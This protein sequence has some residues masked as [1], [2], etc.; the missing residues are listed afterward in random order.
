MPVMLSHTSDAS[1]RIKR[2]PLQSTCRSIY[3]ALLIMSTMLG[4]PL[5]HSHA[6][7]FEFPESG[8]VAATR[9]G[10]AVSGITDAT[11]GFLNPGVLSRLKGFHFSYNHNLIWSDV[12]FT[13]SPSVIPDPY[14]YDSDPGTVRG[15][16][17]GPSS[18]TRSFFPING[19]IALSYQLD[20]GLTLGVS[21]NG[22]NGGGASSFPKQGGQRYMMTKLDAVL[23][24]AGASVAYGGDNWGVG[25]TL[26]LA[27]MP[28]MRYRMVV[29]GE[30]SSQLNPALSALDI[31]AELEV[32]DPAAFTALIGAWFRPI[33]SFEIAISGRVLPVQ[34]E[35]T[36]KV[37]IYNTPN[38]TVYAPEQLVINNSS[39]AF[40]F[41]LPQTAR[42]GLRYRDLVSSDEEGS[43]ERFD[44]E[45]A[46]VYERW[47][48]MD[49][50]DIKLSG[51]VVALN[52]RALQDVQIDKKWRDTFSIRLGGSFAITEV[53][54]LSA[55]GFFEQGATPRQYAHIDFPSF[56]R[57]GVAGGL[58]YQV[59]DNLQLVFGYLHI[60]ESQV[61]VSEL[62][63]KVFQQRP[64]SPCDGADSCGRSPSGEPYSGIPANAGTHRASFRTFTVG[65][66]AS[67]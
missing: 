53:L 27:T 48:V 40:E 24:F 54:G 32:S 31:E 36:G 29:D 8:S 1:Q 61:V 63:A 65:M 43:K 30:N 41:T 59:T 50:F 10:A 52:N 28:D 44:I 42:L 5:S 23:A 22:P 49:Q 3:I 47:S 25:T 57:F 56:D 11:A 58:N 46:L 62:E 35:P 38:Q 51:E 45:L 14:D 16:G 12:S 60:F 67:F 7:G 15:D 6:A 9:G 66:N 13:R 39:A 33:P 34:F 2:Q 18:N 20:S 55:G 21:L 19:L 64:I 26:Q 17:L 4:L 37:N